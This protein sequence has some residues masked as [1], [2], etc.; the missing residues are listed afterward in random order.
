MNWGIDV[1]IAALTIV[2][3]ILDP[4]FKSDTRKLRLLIVHLG[5]REAKVARPGFSQPGVD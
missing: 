2:G 1:G 5:K 4:A 3:D